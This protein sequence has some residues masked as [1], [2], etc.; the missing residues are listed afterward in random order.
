MKR[1]W[2]YLNAKYDIPLDL[3]LTDQNIYLHVCI[4]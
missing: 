3:N 1:W 2:K 4:Q